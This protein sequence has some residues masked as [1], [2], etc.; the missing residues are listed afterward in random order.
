MLTDIANRFLDSVVVRGSKNAK[1]DSL[2]RK[3][4][5]YRIFGGDGRADA[6]A[7]AVNNGIQGFCRNIDAFA[8]RFV[9]F[10]STVITPIFAML[11]VF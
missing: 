7:K 4:G 8:L 5:A 3:Y 10:F 1:I 9:Y 11:R 2:L 6:F